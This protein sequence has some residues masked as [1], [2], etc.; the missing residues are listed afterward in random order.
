MTTFTRRHLNIYRKVFTLIYV[1]E[2]GRNN[3]DF[4]QILTRHQIKANCKSMKKNDG[5][6]VEFQVVNGE[7]IKEVTI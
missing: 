4:G 3:M 6:L 1:F 5:R 7:L 2:V